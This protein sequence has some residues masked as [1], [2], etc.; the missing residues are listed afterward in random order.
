ML[1]TV[2]REAARTAHGRRRRAGFAQSRR[3]ITVASVFAIDPCSRR[4]I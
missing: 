1:R 3:W 4:R 2:H